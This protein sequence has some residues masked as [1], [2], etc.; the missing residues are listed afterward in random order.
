M[1]QN[2][3]KYDRKSAKITAMSGSS[4]AIDTNFIQKPWDCHLNFRKCTRQLNISRFYELRLW[5]L[6]K[7]K[8]REEQWSLQNTWLQVAYL[9]TDGFNLEILPCSFV[10]QHEI[11]I[12]VTIF[13]AYVP[14]LPLNTKRP[15]YRSQRVGKWSLILAH[16]SRPIIRTLT[17]IAVPLLVPHQPRY[18]GSTLYCGL[19]RRIESARRS[20]VQ[21]LLNEADRCGITLSRK[22]GIPPIQLT[23]WCSRYQKFAF[24]WC[25]TIYHLSDKFI[26]GL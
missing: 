19:H 1:T 8:W 7:T 6:V 14:N 13:V 5:S 9:C 11:L 2:G 10:M 20:P 3:L 16:D 18:I 21:R 24:Y 23:I 15:Y 26:I 4:N 17:Y 25:H 12:N 22:N